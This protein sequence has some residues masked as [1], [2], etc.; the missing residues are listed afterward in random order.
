MNLQAEINRQRVKH[1]IDSYQLAQGAHP[2][3]FSTYL[4]DLLKLYP[5]PVVELALVETLVD[6][7]LNVP[8]LRGSKFLEKVYE[9]LQTW[10]TSEV[11][12]AISL[13]QFQQITGLSPHPLL[14]ASEPMPV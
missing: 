10:E 11:A 1:I 3:Q 4:D 13:E 6:E 8:M 7:W 5:T 9:K 2:E 12:I 14:H